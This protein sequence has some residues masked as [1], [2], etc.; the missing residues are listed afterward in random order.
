MKRFFFLPV[1]LMTPFLLSCEGAEEPKSN[2]AAV[3]QANNEFAL[4]LYAKLAQEKGNL[5]FSP[6]SISDALAMTAAGAR[7][8]TLTAMNKTLHLPPDS[9]KVNAGFQELIKALNSNEKE[10]KYQ[11]SVANA[12]WGQKGYNFLPSF[13]KTATDDY[14]AM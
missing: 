3:V 9:A 5:F 4:A 7:G 14:H 11:L 10:R 8:D 12:L 6:Y 13:E 2:Q 1:A